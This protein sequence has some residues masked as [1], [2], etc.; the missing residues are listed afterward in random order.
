MRDKWPI[1]IVPGR[2]FNALAVWLI[3]QRTEIG[4]C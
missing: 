2:F 1:Y 4:R 3:E